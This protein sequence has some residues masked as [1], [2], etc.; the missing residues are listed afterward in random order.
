MIRIR[1]KMGEAGS[2]KVTE[3][4]KS[5]GGVDERGGEIDR[6]ESV[7]RDNIKKG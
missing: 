2:V 7:R 5:I 3:V 4:Y 1:G 6:G